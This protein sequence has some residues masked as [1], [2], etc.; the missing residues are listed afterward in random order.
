MQLQLL[1]AITQNTINNQQL[2]PV[3]APVFPQFGLTEFMRT[4][5]P[6][7]AGSEEAMCADD[8][9]KDVDKVTLTKCND[10]EKVLYAGHQLKGAEA[11]W[12]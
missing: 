2:A 4:R 3:P 5:P 7:I 11:D 12:W 8:W 1:Q 9:L 6:T 10:H